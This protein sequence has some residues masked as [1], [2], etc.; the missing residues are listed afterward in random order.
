MK[1]KFFINVFSLVFLCGCETSNTT[2]PILTNKQM[3]ED[4][5][6]L[7]RAIK[8]IEPNIAIREQVTGTPIMA[9]IDSLAATAKHLKTFEDFYYLAQRILLLCQDQHENLGRGYPSGIEDSNYYISQEAIN[10]SEICDAKYDWYHPCGCLPFFKYVD[11]KYYSFVELYINKDTSLTIP[12]GAELL[13][14]NNI[15]T[16]EYV[17]RY[18]RKIN[19]SVR[20]DNIRKKYYT[21][22]IFSPATIG[23]DTVIVF[24]FCFNNVIKTVNCERLAINSN[25]ANGEWDESV[26][27]FED[28]CLLYVR[29]PEMDYEKMDFYKKEILHYADKPIK[30]VIID[31][32]GNG[33]GSD[34]VWME[35]L[36]YIIDKPI[37]TPTKTYRKNT[38]LLKDYA[39]NIRKDKVCSYSKD[40]VFVSMCSDTTD[41]GTIAP[42]EQSIRYSGKVYVLV[43]ERCFSSS[44]AFISVCERTEKLVTVGKNTGFLKGRSETPYFLTLPNSKL[45]FELI[46]CIDMTNVIKPENHYD[47]AAE[48]PIEPSIEYYINEIAYEDNRY[49]KDFL[50]NHDPIFRAA[51]EA[52]Q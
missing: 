45:I 47:N 46:P 2:I 40:S 41:M 5:A 39:I 8:E 20:W 50:F 24:T 31:I 9:E 21:Y 10:I 44:L 11:G 4:I 28:V 51:L 3:Q 36:S 42:I 7:V 15:P 49:D 6:F 19:N 35:M 38:P 52:K 23:L 34:Y 30:K 1:T 16:D 14:I 33:G 22:N 27:Y 13:A 26:L 17:N 29:V 12:A 48:I 18:N 43:N 37:I 25:V 32:R